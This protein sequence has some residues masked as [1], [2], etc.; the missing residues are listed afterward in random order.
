MIL[1]NHNT[2]TIVLMLRNV[3]LFALEWMKLW[4]TWKQR[5]INYM[6]KGFLKRNRDE[7]RKF[8]VQKGEKNMWNEPVF[9]GEQNTVL[10]RGRSP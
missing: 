6:I 9:K 10:E 7:I 5:L 4:I 1:T 8:I 2:T 3:L